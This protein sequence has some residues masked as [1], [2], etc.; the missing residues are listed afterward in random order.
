VGGDANPAPPHLTVAVHDSDV[1]TVTYEPV[2]AGARGICYLGFEPR[3]YF[4][5]PAASDPV[6]VEVE[7][8]ALATWSEAHTG[9][10]VDP[11][12]LRDLLA[13]PQGDEPEAAY[14]EESVAL[15]L[16]LL[17]LPLPDELSDPH[18]EEDGPGTVIQFTAA[19]HQ[20]LADRGIDVAGLLAF[21]QHLNRRP[22]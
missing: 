17:G 19:N 4:D 14:V 13:S 20:L 9:L 7:A 6:D 10:D 1:A 21:E 12:K 16:A 8:A 15:L 3:H 5:D 11:G 18:G 2:S 22:E